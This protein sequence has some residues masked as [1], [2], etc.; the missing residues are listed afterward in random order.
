MGLDSK[1]TLTGHP[2]MNCL[3]DCKEKSIGIPLKM[4]TYQSKNSSGKLEYIFHMIDIYCSFP[5]ALSALRKQLQLQ[6][7][8]RDS[9]YLNSEYYLKFLYSQLYPNGPPLQECPDIRLLKR[10]GGPLDDYNSH[11]W[12]KMAT[13]TLNGDNIH[14]LNIKFQYIRLQNQKQPNN[15]TTVS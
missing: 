13:C 2:C 5:C 15:N 9:N 4:E 6:P 3:L 7:N 11:I 12:E 8:Y 1:K 10:F 14:L